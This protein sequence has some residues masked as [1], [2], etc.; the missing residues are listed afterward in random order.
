MKVHMME[1]NFALIALLDEK[2]NIETRLS[3]L[4][5]GTMQIRERANNRYVYLYNREDGILT[6]KYAG[7]YSEELNSQILENNKE[8]KGLKQRLRSI[9]R[10]LKTFD[11]IDR[12][13]PER[14][15]RN[16]DFARRSLANSIFRQA[17]LEGV[18]TTYSDTE[19]IIEG[20]KVNGMPAGDVMKIVNLKHAWDFI[21]N[22]GVLLTRSNFNILSNINSLVE[23][24]FYYSA[25]RLRS[26]PVDIGGTSYKPPLPIET[27]VKE[28]LA[29]ILSIADP[30]ERAIEACLYIMRAQL[31]IDGNKRTAIIFANHILI[32]NGLGLI[33]IPEEKVSEYKRLLIEFYE[34]SD[35]KKIAAFLKKNC[36]QRI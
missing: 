36:Y 35:K 20:G 3:S 22:R 29:D 26:V 23:E 24:G 4:L 6:S 32:A 30:F 2:E 14:V 27:A 10:D 11:Y 25:G 8:A 34:T 17:V 16:I 19:A 13:I 33:A 31:F 12:E 15:A 21:L 9:R 18:A 28:N 5:H 7:V 1:S